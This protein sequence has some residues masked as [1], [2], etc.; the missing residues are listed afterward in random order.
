MFLQ[1]VWIVSSTIGG[2]T[3]LLYYR[4]TSISRN[5]YFSTS[6][7]CSDRLLPQ[8]TK[9]ECLVIETERECVRPHFWAFNRWSR[10]MSSITTNVRLALN[11]RISISH[12]P[13]HLPECEQNKWHI[14]MAY[15]NDMLLR[16][17]LQKNG[18]FRIVCKNSYYSCIRVLL[19]II[20]SY[21]MKL[22][23]NT[24]KTHKSASNSLSRIPLR[25]GK[26]PKQACTYMQNMLS[27]ST[28]VLR[29]EKPPVCYMIHI[30]T[31][32]SP[33]CAQLMTCGG[34]LVY[35]CRNK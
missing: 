4:Q 33:A 9:K 27:F 12:F 2:N 14:Q 24:V 3:F 26:T 19:T 15:S 7:D 1:T 30:R 35:E 32:W 13:E 5:K 22:Y 18:P 23:W 29:M 16:D 6:M 34:H 31:I 20:L 25:G 8:K 21:H 11:C 28:L 10:D 17:V